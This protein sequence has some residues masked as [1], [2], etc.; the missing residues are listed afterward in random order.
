ME[1]QEMRQA[2]KE[3]LMIIWRGVPMG[4][5]SRYRMTIWNQF[6]NE[7]RS[8]SYTSS[9]ARFVNSICSHLDADLGRNAA[10]RTRADEILN[11]GNDRAL[12]KILREETMLIVLMVRVAN[13]ERRDEWE[14]L[15]VEEN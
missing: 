9:L 3:L 4:Y 7:V 11:S 13:Q 8:A 5:K 2:A 1:N 6:E 12:L 10:D 14:L 15:H